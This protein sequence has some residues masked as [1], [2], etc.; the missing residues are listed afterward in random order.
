MY[1]EPDYLIEYRQIVK[2]G[3]PK[4]CH[5]C[6]FYGREY[7][8]CTKYDTNPPEDFASTQDACPDYYEIIPF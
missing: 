2:K 7:M 8:F 4:C 1:K 5:T 6:D 3:P